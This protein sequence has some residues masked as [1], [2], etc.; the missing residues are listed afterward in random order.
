MKE[1]LTKLGKRFLGFVALAPV[2][3]A[4]LVVRAGAQQALTNLQTTMSPTGLSNNN[5]YAII[6][7]A[8]STI[9]AILG[10]LLVLL[11]LY[12]GF[13]WMTSQG[14]KDKVEKA[15]QMIYQSVI[16]LL[17][18]FAAY[19]IAAFVITNLQSIASGTA[20]TTGS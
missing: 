6:G 15:K 1:K 7:A 12:A 16:G 14:A 5:P 2:L 20:N 19:A 17:I 3:A 11:I 4:P 10:V 9:L 18:I 13:L 8:I